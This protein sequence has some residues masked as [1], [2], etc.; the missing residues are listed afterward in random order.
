[1]KFGGKKVTGRERNLKLFNIQE[2]SEQIGQAEGGD[3]K[4]QKRNQGNLEG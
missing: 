2:R 3:K 1:M 4:M